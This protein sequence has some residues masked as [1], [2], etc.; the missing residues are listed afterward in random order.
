MEDVAHSLN[1]F[2]I[3]LLNDFSSC[4]EVWE[5]IVMDDHLSGMDGHTWESEIIP[6]HCRRLWDCDNKPHFSTT[7]KLFTR[8]EVPVYTYLD[9]CCSCILLV[10]P[11]DTDSSF[12]H[13]FHLL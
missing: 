3:G 8:W 9:V 5:T 13:D 12:P 4:L 1:L 10:M 2:L 7:V 6:I 11:P